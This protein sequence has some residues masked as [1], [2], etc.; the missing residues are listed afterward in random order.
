MRISSW[1]MR[2]SRRPFCSCKWTS[3]WRADRKAI[4]TASALSC[5]SEREERSSAISAS[6]DAD[7]SAPDGDGFAQAA[8]FRVERFDAGFIAGDVRTARFENFGKLREPGGH[9]SPLAVQDFPAAG[10]R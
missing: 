6:S 3:C 2:T 5:T 7:S 4:S 1:A 10:V 8:A 9:G